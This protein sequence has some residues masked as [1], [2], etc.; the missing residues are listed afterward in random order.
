MSDEK[1]VVKTDSK[2]EKRLNDVEAKLRKLVAWKDGAS[3]N[4]KKFCQT[5]LGSVADDGKLGGYA[6]SW[7]A[8][9]VFVLCLSIAAIAATTI[10]DN[11][12]GP[13]GA[14]FA[15]KDVTGVG[16]LEVK[17]GEGDD[18]VLILDA[19][20]GDNDEDTWTI[21]SE[22]ADNDLSFV[23]HTTERM[24]L[25]AAGVLTVAGGIAAPLSGAVTATT[26]S[27]SS[28]STLTGAVTARGGINLDTVAT[29]VSTNATVSLFD[30]TSTKIDFGGVAAVD[31]GGSGLATTIKG[32]FN[33]DEAATF[34]T[35]VGV[36]GLLTASGGVKF[37]VASDVNVTNGQTVTLA[38]G[39]NVLV[40]IGGTN[41]QINTITLANGAKGQQSVVICK[42]GSTNQIAVA[43]SGNFYG[44]ALALT[45][46]DMATLWASDTN[47]WYG[48]GQ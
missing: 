7:F 34:D 46:A 5:H 18:A 30:T 1:E 38:Y 44:P 15:F 32:T 12:P 24:K 21:E 25:S 33:V 40:P 37:P 31:V 8:S 10:I 14:N 35:T 41:T 2:L 19:D 3:A 45:A 29:L 47:A 16:T 17:G 20:E 9:F 23:N 42:T 36:T 11:K 48:I 28:T 27:A 4:W 26:L 43:Q 13:E 39:I 22:S 6:R